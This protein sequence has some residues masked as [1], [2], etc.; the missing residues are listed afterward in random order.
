MLFPIRVGFLLEDE[1]KYGCSPVTLDY[2]ELV[3]RQWI[4]AGGLNRWVADLLEN[5]DGGFS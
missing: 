1:R 3:P 5:F 2:H 4:G